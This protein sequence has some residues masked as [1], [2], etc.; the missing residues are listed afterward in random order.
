VYSRLND[1]T[2]IAGLAA[3][4]IFL[5]AAGANASGFALKEQSTSAQGNSFAGA[6]AGA[7]DVTYMFFNPAGLT[8]HED[9]QAALL[10]NYFVVQ[11]ETVD[12][13]GGVGGESTSGDAAVDALI[14][15][16]YAMWSLN[17]DL[18]LAIGINAPLGLK[19]EYTQTWAGRYHAVESAM[20]TINVNPAIA[21]R[22]NDV[23]SVGAG[24]QIQQADVTLSNMVNFGGPDLLAEITADDWGFGATFG[25]LAELSD[26]TRFGLGYR[27]Q[28]KHNLKGDFTIGGGL[29]SDAL[30]DFTAP[31]IVS[32]GFYHDINSQWAAMGE[33]A[34][35]RWSSFDEIRFVSSGGPIIQTPEDWDNTWLAALGV[36]WKPNETW[37]LRTGASY[38]Q[39]PIPDNRRTPRLT[40]EDRI[41]V[42]LGA[43]VRVTPSFIIDAAYSHMFIEDGSINLPAGYTTPALPALTANYE[44]SLDVFSVQATMH[45]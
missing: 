22:I 39:T 40:D 33:L 12:A 24:W 26:D 35:T 25:I 28:V 5:F 27:S 31:D 6:T 3:P 30:A 8:R 15:T 32:A 38:D 7:E 1:A 18:K 41:I 16:A 2:V 13:S 45:F 19:T 20:R 34:W 9:H 14:P 11:G 23:L 29:V 37:T 43:Q 42:S 36:T 44:N 10:V 4:L 17:G 21:Y